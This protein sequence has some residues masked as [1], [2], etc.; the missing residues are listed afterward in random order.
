[1][2]L[3]VPLALFGW[4]PAVLLLFLFL[5]LR[6]ATGLA[7]SIG[8]CFLPMAGYTLPGFPDYSKM[9]A[10]CIG[11]LLG[12]SFFHTT[13]LFTYRASWLDIATLVFCFSPFLSS[14]ANG[15]GVYDGAS[16]VLNHSV[17]WGLPYFIGRLVYRRTE[18]LN[19][20]AGSIIG[21]ALLYVP[22]CLWEV[23][24]SPQLHAIFYGFHQ[25]GFEQTMRFGGWRPT[26]FMEHGL[27]VALWMGFGLLI[28]YVYLRM[29]PYNSKSKL[30][31]L[32]LL[33]LAVTFL[34]L[35]SFGA[36]VLV[37]VAIGL[38]ELV[39]F[40]R[41]RWLYLILPLW[42]V[43]YLLVRGSG[44]GA[45]DTLISFISNNISEDRAASL[46][47]RI[48]NE[49][50]LSDQARKQV[51]LG[52]GGWGRNRVFDEYGKDLTV[53]D[54]L[55]IIIFGT[56]GALGLS[57][58][59]A[60]QLMAPTRRLLSHRFRKNAATIGLALGCLIASIDT[61]PNA[62]MLPIF[63]LVLGALVHCEQ[64]VKPKNRLK[65]LARSPR[66]GLSVP[67]AL[68]TEGKPPF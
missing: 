53:T 27:Q 18:D 9:F 8:W 38:F 68:P 67:Q 51:W 33:S 26:V 59:Y 47:F 56:Q 48:D 62:M 36:V 19:A 57:A 32:I 23:R 35:K 60:M 20:L 46:Q 14:I 41:L 34:F 11:A 42:V 17:T 2:S 58:F 64:R 21:C 5:P 65:A 50:L 7:F 61:L 66:P 15:L 13:L 40:T 54:G 28:C 49:N 37:A 4:I 16:A 45:P 44:L 52:W 6:W 30:A 29:T 22:L 55:W 39:Q 31:S 1:L 12:I 63:Q 10:T 24:M 43:T 3:L 25:H